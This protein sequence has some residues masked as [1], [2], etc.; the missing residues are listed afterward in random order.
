MLST[1]L[2]NFNKI[3]GLLLALM[4]LMI[5]VSEVNGQRIYATSNRSGNTNAIGGSGSVALPDNATD[6]NYSNSAQ[7]I[8][9]STVGTSTAWEQLIFSSAIPAN[10]TAYIK[11]K[12]LTVGLLGGEITVAAYSGSSGGSPGTEGTLVTSTASPILTDP[13][14]DQ[15]VLVTPTANINSVKI[16]LRSPVA[17]G[18]NTIDLYYAYYEQPGTGCSLALAT[19]T[20]VTGISVGGSVTTPNNAI[21]NNLSTSSTL[22]VGLLGVAA[23][24]KQMVYF[25]S[26]ST[27]GD[28]ATVSFGVPPGVLTLG[29]FD[30]IVLT[31]YNGPTQVGTPIKFSSLLSLD[32]LYLGGGSRYTAS[33]VPSG[34]FDRIEIST[35]SLASVLGSLYLYEVQRTPSKPTFS[36]PTLQNIT[37]CSG[38]QVTLTAV[39]PGSGNELRWYSSLTATTPLHTGNT[40][41]PAPT[42]TSTY[43]VA[44]AKTGCTAESERVPVV[45][46]VNPLP[47]APAGTAATIC[48][49]FNGTF[50]VTSPNAAYTYNWYAASTGGS[51]ILT[52][53]SVVTSSPLSANLTYYLEAT[54]TATG[55]K[56]ATRTAV[57]ITVNPLPGITLG[58]SPSACIG[59]STAALT[60]TAT[61]GTPNTYS[62]TWDAAALAAG[63]SNVQGLALPASPVT[64][65]VPATAAITTYTGSLTVKNANGCVSSSQNISLFIRSKPPHPSVNITSN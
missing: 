24:I 58:G 63:F 25:S 13:N 12:V 56:S 49:G 29:L 45:V 52:G 19:S 65:N 3:Y 15:Y 21:D 1:K 41:S 18:T 10:S 53:T 11:L 42:S 16:T 26:L 44:T 31:A 9:S 4:L 55:C 20:S 57:T 37:S 6:G 43:Y 28:A 64:L 39:S 50:Q 59:A 47:A 7:L 8:A 35:N 32:L 48:S 2:K 34:P 38:A 30:G 54:I 22:A 14:G 51:A 46:T 33:F 62:I 36:S 17:L 60:Y 61:T 5:E 40:F 23:S 27:T